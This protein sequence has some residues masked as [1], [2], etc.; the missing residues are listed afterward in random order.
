MLY[1]VITPDIYIPGDRSVA[2]KDEILKRGYFEIDDRI[3][4]ELNS[5]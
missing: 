5:L 1:E 4:E 2:V 3:L